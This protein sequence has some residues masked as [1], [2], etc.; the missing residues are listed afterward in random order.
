MN[1]ENM[2][3][4][5]EHGG[6]Q[7][8]RE[9]AKKINWKKEIF[10]WVYTIA[11]ALVIAFLI[12][13][14]LFDVVKVDGSSMYPTLVDNDRLIVTKLG[15][16]PEV[17][18][19][20]ILDSRYKAR[21]EYFAQEAAAEGKEEY[22]SLTKFFK[23]TFSVPEEYERKYYVK[24]VIALPGQT[25]SLEDNKLHVDGVEVEEEYYDGETVSIDPSVEYPITVEEGMV[26]VLGD[27]RMHSKDSR[28]SEL[29]QVPFEAILGKS[30]LR[31]YPF[32]SIGLT[33]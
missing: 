29:G 10:E 16:E 21:E 23:T 33:R 14:F 3:T 26:F 24:R 20:V 6:E 7:E 22:S 30:Q 15:Y 17:G 4:P 8:T 27:N 1:E 28:S 19:I 2:N 13:A 25:V 31:I 9:E 5:N 12:K 32:S 11:I 18:D